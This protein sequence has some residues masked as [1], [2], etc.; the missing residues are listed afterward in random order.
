MML[1]SLQSFELRIPFQ[2]AFKHASAER[3][4]TQTMWVEARERGGLTGF[5]EGCPREYVTAESLHSART[6]F[7]AHHAEWLNSLWDVATLTEWAD[8]H[9]AEIDLNPAAW[10]A[11]ELALLD[12]MGKLRGCSV[13]SLFSLPEPAGVCTYTAVLGSSAPQKFVAQLTQYLQAGFSRFKIKLSGEN[14][15]D[16]AAVRAL[17]EAAI[18]PEQV[19]ADANNLW[20]DADEAIGALRAL[21][22]PF[23]AVEEPLVAG[24]LDGMRS[25][26]RSLGARIILDETILR[27]EQLACLSADAPTWIINVRVSKM[28]GLLRTLELLAEAR[29]LGLGV[30]IGA[31][32]GESS[33]L[34]R[35]AL[36]AAA[37][38]GG[39]LV[40]QEGAFGTLLL[41]SDVVERPIMFGAGGR[42]DVGA[43]RL[44]VASGF[45]LEILKPLPVQRAAEE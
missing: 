27:T 2:A 44:R 33:L 42:L 34:T 4:A 10:C 13:E 32:V 26:A 7:R 37:S 24:D 16:R 31:H 21:D 3:A 14:A 38:A 25:I 17:S 19:R 30:V 8:R 45:G 1:E 5:G 29:R 15:S 36:T 43:L 18:A 39:L 6:F 9:R 11:V 23:F 40:G 12:L 41:A 35:A 28:G 20:S 22:Y